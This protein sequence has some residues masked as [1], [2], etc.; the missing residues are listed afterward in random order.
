MHR[1]R[2]CSFFPAR[3]AVCCAHPPPWAPVFGPMPCRSRYTLSLA[4]PI[5]R[6]RACHWM[7]RGTQR[8]QAVRSPGPSDDVCASQCF[9]SSHASF[10]FRSFSP[11]LSPPPPPP[12][13]LLQSNQC[14]NT[15][16]QHECIPQAI[17][18]GDVLCQ[19]SKQKE[20]E[21]ERERRDELFRPTA[22]SA[23]F[24]PRL[25]LPPRSFPSSFFDPDRQ[26]KTS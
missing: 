23:S 7:G 13:S 18:G 5:Q 15:T 20:V 10:F 4:G 11:L 3:R 26:K 24:F 9:C 19:V 16:V 1:R 6:P 8:A 21:R 22:I 25:F 17:L 14:N 12:P 2:C